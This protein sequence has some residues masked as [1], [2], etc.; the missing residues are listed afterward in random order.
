MTRRSENAIIKITIKHDH[1]EKTEVKAPDVFWGWSGNTKYHGQEINKDSK[2]VD[3]S[4]K[5]E[6]RMT[7][8][9]WEHAGQNYQKNRERSSCDFGTRACPICQRLLHRHLTPMQETQVY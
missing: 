2:Q 6:M 4:R 8:E 7:G 1:G 5:E 9:A 3:D